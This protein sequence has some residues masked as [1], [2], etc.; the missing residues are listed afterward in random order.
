MVPVLVAAIGIGLVFATPAV[1]G[2]IYSWQTENG[3]VAF[4]D[5][6]KKIP[7]RYRS[8][9]QK[10]TSERIEDY[11]RFSSG[12]SET[13]NRYAEQLAARVDALRRFN[14][15]RDVADVAPEAVNGVASINV[16]GIDLR[17]PGAEIDAPIIVENVRV[18][19]DGQITSR[20]DSVVRQ[21]GRTL[22]IVRGRQEGEVGGASSILDEQDL[23][24]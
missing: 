19:G 23:E 9:A 7:A 21:G 11:A 5:N 2:E 8:Q 10:R 24:F 22:A 20:H 15:V 14:S 1:A 16:R 3:E 4:T 12:Q 18:M 17:I 6:P 13:T